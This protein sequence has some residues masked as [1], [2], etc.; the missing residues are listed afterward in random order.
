MIAGI[1]VLLVLVE[2]VV[3]VYL[4][5]RWR[6]LMKEVTMLER[7]Y[8][9]LC[10]AVSGLPTDDSGTT[11]SA[12]AEHSSDAVEVLQN[13]TPEQMEAAAD[14]LAKLGLTPDAKG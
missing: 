3:S 14:I 13:A 4:L 5:T 8:D 7:S 2:L 9:A 1:L 6:G 10:K 12:S 11:S